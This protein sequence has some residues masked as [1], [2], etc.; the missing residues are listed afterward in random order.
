MG[1]KVDCC[2]ILGADE[3]GEPRGCAKVAEWQ[4]VSGERDSDVTY[5][6]TEHVGYLL[7]DA[8]GQRIYPMALS[9]GAPL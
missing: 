2:F 5:A 4:I 1:D 6:C 3:N 9:A 8:P 7:C